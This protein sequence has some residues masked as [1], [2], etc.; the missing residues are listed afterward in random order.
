MDQLFLSMKMV[1]KQN[2]RL[3]R[4]VR[5]HS[6]FVNIFFSSEARLCGAS[7]EIDV[8]NI[9]GASSRSVLIKQLRRTSLVD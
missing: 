1:S 6:L 4:E 2:L 7:M 8:G 9:Y 3:F 5:R